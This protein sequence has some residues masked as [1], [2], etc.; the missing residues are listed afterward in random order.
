MLAYEGEKGGG[1]KW[2]CGKY[3][4]GK[5]NEAGMYLVDWCEEMGMAHVNNFIR[6]KRR[7]T[8]RHPATWRC[9]ELDGFLVRGERD[10]GW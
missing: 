4:L 1:R 9:H 3:G 7:G 5:G 6:Y 8:W 2:V 10:R